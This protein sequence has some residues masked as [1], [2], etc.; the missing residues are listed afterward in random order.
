M[1]A[2]WTRRKAKFGAFMKALRERMEPRV[3]PEQVA[4]M[5]KSNRSTITRMESGNSL[6]N[7]HFVSALL[8]VYGAS[9]D[10]RVKAEQLWD[11]AKQS[12]T[13]IEHSADQPSK[14]V[15]FRREEGDAVRERTIQ[16][17][18]LA[19]LL[20]TGPYASAVAEAAKEFNVG[21]PA[22][23]E[24][25]AA[26]ERKTRQLLLQSEHPLELHAIMGEGVIRCE[27][28]GP[29]VMAEQLRHLLLVGEHDH[30]TIQI[31]P[32][33]AGAF[34]TM[35]GPSTILDFEDAED[36]STVYVEYAAGGEIVDTEDDVKAFVATFDRVSRDVALSPDESAELIRVVLAELEER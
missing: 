4:P 15:A 25:R 26:A 17:V 36:P 6:P 2:E 13:K 7:F 5:V 23:W 33:H 22:G 30:I 34:G 11:S 8:G 3:T 19:G 12:G 24:L 21:R 20:Q 32:F 31:V 28:G 16:P 10:E 14:Y 29:V 9:G 27:V 35:S 18:A 1:A